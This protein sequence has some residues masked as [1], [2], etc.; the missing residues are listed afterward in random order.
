MSNNRSQRPRRGI[1]IVAV[2]ACCVVCVS[3]A[4]TSLTQAI[5]ARREAREA[6]QR[7]QTRLLLDAAVRLI[8]EAETSS[9]EHPL[10][11]DVSAA[12]PTASSAVI[13]CQQSTNAGTDAVGV[14]G[15][16]V[17]AELTGQ[18]AAPMVTR[19]SRPIVTSTE[20]S[21]AEKGRR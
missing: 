5:R 3:L 10:E 20:D 13:R 4:C 7:E 14:K 2:L 12:Y 19:L 6:L 8:G 11:I 18:G 15:V 17:V 9:A 1:V 21:P 16:V